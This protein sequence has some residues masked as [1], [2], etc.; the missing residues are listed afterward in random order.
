M[1][2]DQ[3]ASHSW[4]TIP[5]PPELGILDFRLALRHHPD[6]NPNLPEEA[7]KKFQQITSAYETIMAHLKVPGSGWLSL[8]DATRSKQ[9]MPQRAEGP[10]K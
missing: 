1:A 2:P 9:K 5:M 8:F 6:K 3:A 4:A 7:A 10:R